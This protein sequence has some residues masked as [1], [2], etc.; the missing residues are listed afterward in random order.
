MSRHRNPRAGYHPAPPRGFLPRAWRRSAY[1]WSSSPELRWAARQRGADPCG[2]RAGGRRNRRVEGGWPVR[3]RIGTSSGRALR[4]HVIPPTKMGMTAELVSAWPMTIMLPTM[5]R[6]WTEQTPVRWTACRPIAAPSPAR[7]G[8]GAGVTRGGGAATSRTRPDIRPADHSR[9][10]V[11]SVPAAAV[12]PPPQVRHRS[13]RTMK[14]TRRRKRRVRIH[15][16]RT[17]AGA[18]LAQCASAAMKQSIAPP[19]GCDARPS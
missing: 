9:R 4:Q 12:D 6:P 3:S 2:T 1:A 18:R 14:Q 7:C 10:I 8:R 11:G 15:V 5:I 16:P 19:Q 17:A 13:G